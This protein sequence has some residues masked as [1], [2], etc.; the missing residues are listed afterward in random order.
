MILTLAVPDE[1][2]QEYVSHYP[3][4]VNK[5]MVEQLKRFKDF[6]PNERALILKKEVRQRLERIYQLPIEDQGKFLDWLDKVATFKVGE[7]EVELSPAQL[8]VVELAAAGGRMTAGEF[9]KRKVEEGLRMALG[10]VA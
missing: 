5:G 10:G 1:L 2:Y 6:P 3:T 7:V 9:L 8:R 4:G